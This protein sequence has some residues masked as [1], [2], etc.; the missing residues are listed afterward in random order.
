[1]AEAT[2]AGS[3]PNHAGGQRGSLLVEVMLAGSMIAISA[4]GL[5]AAMVSGLTL[6]AQSRS[7]LDGVTTAENLM[8]QARATSQANFA[9]VVTDFN[10]KATAAN[11]SIG[12]ADT[13]SSENIQIDIPLDETVVP[14]GVDLNGDGTVETAVSPS[15]AR[16]LVLDVS[17]PYRL[18]MRSAVVNLKKLTGLSLE[19]ESLT[20]A[21]PVHY[22]EVREPSNPNAQTETVAAPAPTADD[23]LANTVELS[24]ASI[25]GKKAQLVVVNNGTTERRPVSV[26]VSPD[27]PGLYFK[28]IQLNSTTVYTAPTNQPCG[29]VT[30]P[31]TSTLTFAP[32]EATL[33]IGTF[34]VRDD[35]GREILTTPWE[36]AV[37]VAYDDGSITNATVR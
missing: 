30:V 22:G 17:G 18:R 15:A 5:S 28:A 9:Q 11:R 6:G 21:G 16:L 33:A 12:Y 32:G 2:I 36:V 23:A 1:V 25:V 13:G 10:E 3:I 20:G 26:T 4:L 37:T 14:G 29:T 24:A 34:Y 19:R 27:R 7:A 35:Q 8:E 31:L